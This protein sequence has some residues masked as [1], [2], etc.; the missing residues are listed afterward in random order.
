MRFKSSK[1]TLRVFFAVT[2]SFLAT[3]TAFAK[4]PQKGDAF[5]CTPDALKP[6][7]NQAIAS[8][9]VVQ[10]LQQNAYEQISLDDLSSEKIFNNYLEQLDKNRIYFLQSDINSF[11]LYLNELD[12]ALKSGNLKPAFDIFNVYMQRNKERIEFYLE[13]LNTGIDQIDL[14]TK[15][16]IDLNR[17]DTPWLPDVEMQHD[18]WLK[19][20]KDSILSMKLNKKEDTEIQTLLVKRYTNQLRR[21][22]QTRNE[23][24]FQI[25]LN[26]FTQLYDPH[27]QYFSPQLAESFDINMSLSLEGIGAVLQSEDEYTKVVNVL[28]AGPADKAGQLKPGDKII[29]VAQGS[30][31]HFEDVVGQRLDEVV[32]HIRGA[33]GTKVFLEVIPNNSLDGKT[34]IYG[35]TRDKVKLEEQAAQKKLLT[36]KNKK[37]KYNIGIITIPAFYID[38]KAAQ[39]GDINYKSTTRDVRRLLSE[40]T[41]SQVDGL[42]VDL[43]NNGGGSLQEANQLAGLFIPYGPTVQVRDNRGHTELQQ[44]P[45]PAEVFEKPMAVLINRLSASASEIFAGAM[46]DY[47]RAIILGDQSFGKG[48][49]Q[50]I[51]PLNHGHLKLTIAKFYRISGQSTQNRGIIP[52]IAFPSLFSNN[53]IGESSLPNSLPWDSIKPAQYR[54]FNALTKKELKKLRS[55]HKQR[56]QSNPDFKYFN[57]LLA[58]QAELDQNK[59]VS[60]NLKNRQKEINS[61]HKKR[62][63]IENTLRRAKGQK[64][65]SSMEELENEQELASNESKTKT[66][67]DE[68]DDAFILEA[69]NVLSDYIKLV[70][71]KPINQSISQNHNMVLD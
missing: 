49:V 27:T 41:D 55:Y 9:N 6:S 54:S 2:L 51:Q 38:F 31:N 47:N 19:L 64:L 8:V 14:N 52:D 18:L 48:T 60:L 33:K 29:G 36:V 24:A 61:F 45:D 56:T 26:S 4:T 43:R 68:D 42:I 15:E 53:E 16:T 58:L 65:L 7:L 30:P 46:Q 37:K 10:L 69:A 12:G 17:D 25:Y 23:D 28:P 62:L 40:L 44:D 71:S 3:F 22:C 50:T 57:E 34:R 20:L 11:S 5:S 1:T 63:D 39:K 35:I 32:K 21:L 67:Q 70:G 13:T 59:T 66:Q